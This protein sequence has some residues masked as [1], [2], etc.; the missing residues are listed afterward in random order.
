M[1]QV[2]RVDRE[3]SESNKQNYNLFKNRKFGKRKKKMRNILIVL[4]TISLFAC[5]GNKGGTISGKIE[6]LEGQTIYLESF[7][8]NH[9]VY[10]DSTVAGADGSFTIKPAQPL[11]LDYYQIVLGPKQYI[12]LITDSSECIEVKGDLSNLNESLR[13]EGSVNSE[14]LRDFDLACIPFDK[15]DEELAQ[16]FQMPGISEEEK[17]QHMQSLVE[18]RKQRA[19]FV[20][21][22]LET[23]SSTPAALLAIQQL[24]PKTDMATFQNVFSD[25]KKSFG[26]SA[27]YKG[28]KQQVQMVVTKQNQPA[29]PKTNSNVSVGNVAPEI[30]LPDPKGAVRKLSS[31]RGKTVLIDFWASWC[32][33]CRRENPNVVAAYKKYNK[34]GFEVYSVS[35]DKAKE[36]WTQAIADDGLIWKNHVS[37]LKWW[38]SEAAKTYGVSSIPFTVLIDKDGKVLG[39]NLRGAALEAELASIYGHN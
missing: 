2:N 34:D 16:K 36:S 38:D 5:T 39:Y 1:N 33:P 32:G 15:K 4:L 19:D 13:I 27:V 12:T 25:L 31:L 17:Q 20:K 8:N 24:D 3:H 37:D 14:A 18:N 22:W 29:P 9:S 10:T 28:I 21:K 11:Q 30:S 7:A 23:N 6:G 35:L 26:H